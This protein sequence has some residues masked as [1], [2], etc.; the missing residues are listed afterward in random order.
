MLSRE[1]QDVLTQVG[2]GTKCGEWLRAF[3]FPIAVSD[4]WD[5][6]G[7][8]LVLDEPVN[9]CGRSGTATSFGREFGTFRGAPMP[10]RILGEELVLYRDRSGTL[11]LIDRA[12]PHRN[13]SMEYGRPRERGI[14]CA[15]HGWTF[16]ETGRCL[17]MPGEPADSTFKDKVRIGAYAVQETG[18]LIWA[19]LGEGAAPPLPKIDVI[20]RADGV[21]VVENFCL[22]PANWLQIVENSVDQV[23][24]GILHGEDS[25]RAD[26]WSRIPEVDWVP[27]D[28][29]I[30]TVQIRGDY[31]RT[32]Y[33]HLP[34]T[35]LLNQP[36]PGGKFG[37]PRYSAIFR[38]PVDDNNTL[39]FHV[40]LVPEVNGRKPELPPGMIY[41]VH[42]LVQTL[43]LQDYRA[44]VSQGRPADRTTERLGT[45]DRGIILWRKMVLDG[46]AA[47]EAGRR[48][49]GVVPAD[50]ADAII[51]SSVKVTDGLMT[52]Q[53]AA[54]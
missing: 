30:Q 11:G 37:W 21:R 27:D 24:T 29:G 17:A 53:A 5:G 28:T 34:T 47:V 48:P 15:Y 20:A 50:A 12:C 40:T 22:W 8:Q 23:H 1:H 52:P 13:S 44:I 16:D 49:A 46:I 31:R 4:R 14:S 2:K 18:G 43:F 10:V 25:A 32:N 9:F 7:G 39:L 26:V 41:P 42:E 54:E 38:T 33:L 45:T 3:W 19:W 36:W 6:P 35:I 51:D